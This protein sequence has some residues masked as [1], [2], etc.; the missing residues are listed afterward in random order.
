MSDRESKSRR[1]D[2]MKQHSVLFKG[3]FVISEGKRIQET[4]K[5][6]GRN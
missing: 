3:E 4:Y 2:V 6:T 5:S 1:K